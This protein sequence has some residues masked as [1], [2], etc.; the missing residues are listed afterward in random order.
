MQVMTWQ[1]RPGGELTWR[2]GP[3]HKCDAAL[4]PRGRAKVSHAQDAATGLGAKRPR[5]STWAL[6]WGATWQEGTA[7]GGP[8]GIVGPW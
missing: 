5:K 2:A 6:V 3:P 8:M 4:R 1:A 7:V